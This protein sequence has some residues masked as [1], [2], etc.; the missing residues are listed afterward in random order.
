[1]RVVAVELEELV[2]VPVGDGFTYS[3]SVGYLGVTAVFERQ[4]LEEIVN[5]WDARELRRSKTERIPAAAHLDDSK[6]GDS[7]GLGRP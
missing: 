2:V 6:C 5:V 7:R 1:M 4:I 3:E